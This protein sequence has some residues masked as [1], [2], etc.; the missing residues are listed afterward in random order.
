VRMNAYGVSLCFVNVH[1]RAH[2]ENYEGRILVIINN[3]S[4]SRSLTLLV[5]QSSNRLAQYDIEY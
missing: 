5:Y 3:L 2:R 1:F 4:I